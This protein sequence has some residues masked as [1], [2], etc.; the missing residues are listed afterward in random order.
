MRL[1]HFLFALIL[2]SS[3]FAD[4]KPILDW[5]QLPKAGWLVTTDAWQGPINNKTDLENCLDDAREDLKDARQ[6]KKNVDRVVCT[7]SQTNL[8]NLDGYQVVL[9]DRGLIVRE[10]RS[11]ENCLIDAKAALLQAEKKG[12]DVYSIDCRKVAHEDNPEGFHRMLR[13]KPPA[14]AAAPPKERLAS[15]ER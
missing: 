14:P 11:L 2:S 4:I 1:F 7:R 12:Q 6:H 15:I 10:D 8:L 5:D 13:G 3:L 9:Y